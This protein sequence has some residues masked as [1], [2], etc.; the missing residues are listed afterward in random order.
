MVVY[1]EWRW[2]KDLA[3][4]QTTYDSHKD[5]RML[6]QRSALAGL[7]AAIAILGAACTSAPPEKEIATTPEIELI[8]RQILFG[9]PTRFRAD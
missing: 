1:D 6:N 8:D 7:I 2:A 4:S 9:N 3:L 5:R